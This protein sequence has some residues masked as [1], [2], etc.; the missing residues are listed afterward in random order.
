MQ[1]NRISSGISDSTVVGVAADS[2]RNATR[3]RHVGRHDTASLTFGVQTPSCDASVM[4]LPTDLHLYLL[5]LLQLQPL[6]PSRPFPRDKPAQR[7]SRRSVACRPAELSRPTHVCAADALQ[8]A[9]VKK[10]ADRPNNQRS[11]RRV[12]TEPDSDVLL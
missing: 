5:L 2:D 7:I 11:G 4:R 10:F 9:I 3:D 6:Q 8:S 1:S 12:A